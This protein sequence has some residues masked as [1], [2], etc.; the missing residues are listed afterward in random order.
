MISPSFHV[1]R[2][3]RLK[4]HGRNHERLAHV[5]SRRSGSYIWLSKNRKV[6]FEYTEVKTNKGGKDGKKAIRNDKKKVRT[7][8]KPC[9]DVGSQGQTAQS[10]LM[11]NLD[12]G[13]LSRKESCSKCPQLTV[14]L[15]EM[16]TYL[17]SKPHYFHIQG[18]ERKNRTTSGNSMT[19]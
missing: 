3:P 8:W 15:R 4:S 14:L 6:D 10:G 12:P 9:V 11:K 2:V 5:P 19:A 1:F 13:E 16:R 18:I 7:P 17:L